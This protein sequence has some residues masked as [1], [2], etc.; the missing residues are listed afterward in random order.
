MTVLL[1][2]LINA[3]ALL[4]ITYI[5]PSI[6]IKSFGT[7]LIVALVLGLINAIIRPLLI[8]FTLPLT[9]L[10]LGLFILVINALCF[11]LSATLLKG[12]E[13][14]GFWSA[15]FG[16]ILY[17]IVSYLLSALILGHRFTVERWY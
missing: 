15:F 16:S 7:A 13:V 1:T 8:L 9:V 6:Q 11:W 2:W 3:L 4:I 14:S 17:S 10:T 12:F 5:V